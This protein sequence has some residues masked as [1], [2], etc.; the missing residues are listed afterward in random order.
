MLT[1]LRQCAPVCE[2]VEFSRLFGDLRAAVINQADERNVGLGLKDNNT[3]WRSDG[4]LL[5]M[6]LLNLVQNAIHACG[7]G[8]KVTV[9]AD[10]ACIEVRDDGCGMDEESLA[11]VTEPFYRVDKSRSRA[12]GG[13][14]LGLSI[15][16]AIC[17]S[18]G[19]SLR[20]ESMKGKGTSVHVLQVHDISET[21]P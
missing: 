4:M 2:R 7:K 12:E 5:Y 16:R 13:A 3:V 18:L 6:L 11:H 1:R 10:T 9:T 17:D 15:C 8:G 19:L 14:G 20:I 21:A